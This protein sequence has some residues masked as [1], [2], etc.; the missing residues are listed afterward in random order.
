MITAFASF[1]QQISIECLLCAED[2]EE[3]ARP[4]SFQWWSWNDGVDTMTT[5]SK[6]SVLLPWIEVSA[7]VLAHQ[8]L[9]PLQKL[10]IREF[11]YILSVA[12]TLCVL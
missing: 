7:C 5:T 4:V 10:S 11:V 12:L 1:I 2:T 8:L 9:R 3:Q 6:N